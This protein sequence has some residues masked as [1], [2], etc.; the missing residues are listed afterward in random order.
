MLNIWKFK[1]L[2]LFLTLLCCPMVQAQSFSEGFNAE[3]IG[4]FPSGVAVAGDAGLAVE[5]SVTDNFSCHLNLGVSTLITTR[6]A[7]SLRASVAVA[8]Y[9]DSDNF[10]AIYKLNES[11][12]WYRRTGISYGFFLEQRILHYE[13]S[14]HTMFSS[15]AGGAL[16]Y[17]RVWERSQLRAEAQAIVYV[18]MRSELS[19]ANYLQRVR[20]SA[21]VVKPI[22]ERLT[23]K[24]AYH[25]HIGGKEQIYFNDRHGLNRFVL[26]TC[27]LIKK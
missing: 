25:S 8:D 20:L 9:F 4:I 11:I 10:D 24:F 17:A 16:S 18:N 23:L 26:S 1:T 14:Q 15:C 5:Q 27:L 2:V 6:A 13:P 12:Y 7:V 3:S 22:S 19:S 21:S